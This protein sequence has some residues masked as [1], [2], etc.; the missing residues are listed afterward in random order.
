MREVPT[1]LSCLAFRVLKFLRLLQFPESGVNSIVDA[2]LAP[3]VRTSVVLTVDNFFY[4]MPFITTSPIH[5]HIVPSPRN[6]LSIALC[7]AF[8]LSSL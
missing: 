8:I 2:A 3:P 4:N 1:I 6:E 7:H 5:L